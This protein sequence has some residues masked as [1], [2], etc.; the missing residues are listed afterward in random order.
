MMVLKGKST[1]SI[2]P[3]DE[4]R[5]QSLAGEVS[6]I[7]LAKISEQKNLNRSGFDV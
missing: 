3:K 7:L 4:R 5:A 6:A 2:I 1:P